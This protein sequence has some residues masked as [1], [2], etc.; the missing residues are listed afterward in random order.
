MKIDF[1][2]YFQI[3]FDIN[4]DNIFAKGQIDK[5]IMALELDLERRKQLLSVR[6]N[7][8]KY[9]EELLN[10]RATILPIASIEDPKTAVELLLIKIRRET[11][12]SFLQ[13]SF[14]YAK[15]KISSRFKKQEVIKQKVLEKKVPRILYVVNALA[16]SG[17]MQIIVRHCNELKKRGYD[18]GILTFGPYTTSPWL[19]VDVPVLYL[20]DYPEDFLN[21]AEIMVATH[22][23]T[24]PY[25]SLAQAKRK[26]YFVQS[27]E[28]RFILEKKHKENLISYIAETYSM[29]MEFMT[30]AIWIQ[31]WL[32]EEFGKEAYYVPNGLDLNVFYKTDPVE[33]KTD[34]PRVLLE[35]QINYWLKG[36]EEG[37]EAIKDL[38]C[39]KWIIS[40]WGKPPKHWKYDRF[41]EKVPFVNMKN[42]Y[43]SCDIL[44]KMSKVEG[45]F[46]SPMEGMACGCI[47]VVNKVSGYDEY[48]QH[49][50]NGM[51]VNEG[52]IDGVKKA[53]QKIIEDEKLKKKLIENGYKTAKEWNWNH[54]IDLLEEMIKKKKV[55]KY[56]TNNFPEKYDFL[57]ERS[58]VDK[59]LIK[60]EK[61]LF[62]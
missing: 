31:R 57:A 58:K 47:S 29:D 32:K 20:S 34:R 14:K 9:Y 53:I 37:Y 41:F 26:V 11:F 54:S 50:E 23:S 2:K 38:D 45:F 48:I 30:E 40:S 7:D 60:R 51:V 43:S 28:R 10:K 56:Y 17:G 6:D 16:I 24:A 1:K 4:I 36:V 62:S 8:L 19:K 18:V 5:K 25:V 61:Y 15:E 13:K 39:E 55:K 12:K 52:D 27:D 59:Y 35:G 21:K 42:L 3:E 49:K 46:G 44:V 33:P 22:W